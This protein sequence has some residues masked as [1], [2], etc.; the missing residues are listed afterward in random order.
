MESSGPSEIFVKIFQVPAP[1]TFRQIAE[2]SPA[3]WIHF[4]GIL[5][6]R[7]N[8]RVRQRAQ[9][10]VMGRLSTAVILLLAAPALLAQSVG[11]AIGGVITDQSGSA[12]V[13]VAVSIGDRISGRQHVVTTGSSGEYRV[14]ALPPS[15]YR[16]TVAVSGFSPVAENVTLNVNDDATLDLELA[17]A[18]VDAGV[19]STPGAIDLVHHEPSSIVTEEQIQSL[20]EIGRN[21]LQLAQLL[22]GSAPLNAS[23]NRFATTRFGGAADQ[24]SAVTTLIDGG[25]VDDAQ[26]G[27]PTINLSQDGVQEF[28]VY[29]NQFGAQYG[30]ALNA[31]VSVVTKSGGNRA[32]G[33]GFYFGRDAALNARNAFARETPPFDEQRLGATFGGPIA[34][35]RTHIFSAYEYDHVDTAR[36][37]AHPPTSRFAI[38]NGVFPAT[39]DD[40]MFSL[41]IDHQFSAG[42]TA[43][44]RYAHAN[45]NIV[46]LQQFPTS[47]SSQ[48][49]TFSRAHSV[50]AEHHAELSPRMFN[51]LRLHVFS[52]TSGGVPH[53]ADRVAAVARPSVNM[54]LVN[55]GE[56]LTFPRTEITVA[57]TIYTTRGRHD[58]SFGGEMGF[59]RNRLEGRFFED[60]LFRFQTDTQFDRDV[61]ATWP[62]SFVQQRP[63][64]DTYRTHPVA[65]FVQDH[66]RVADRLRVN[67][68]LR[69]DL[70]PTLRLN[71]V[72]AKALNDPALS[73][74]EAFVSR[75]RGTDSN[76]L[77]PR[78]GVTYDVTGSGTVVARGGFG[79]Y[80]ARN[81]PWFQVRAMNQLSGYAIRIEDPNQ[82]RLYPDVAAVVG[83]GGPRE[84]GTVIPDEFSQASAL[85]TTAGVGW[86]A[87]RDVSID[88]DY[89]HSYGARQYGTT[90]RNLPPTGT[91]GPTNPRP[92]PQF[93]QVAMLE[94]F[95]TSWHHALESQLRM[96]LGHR[97]RVQVSYTLSRTFLDG[98]DFFLTQRGTQ[99]TPQERGYS[100]SDQRHNLALAA[101]IAM[102]AGFD[103]SAILKLVSGSPLSVQAGSDLDG[104]R[105]PTGDRPPGLPITVGRADTARDLEI[106]NSF[107]ATLATPLEAVSP[108]LLRLEP[109]R[110]LDARLT[111]TWIVGGDR[112]IELLF[113]AFNLL[114]RVNFVVSAASRN[115]NS[116]QFLFRTS[117]RDARQVQWGARLRF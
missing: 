32:S 31:V 117:A 74:L 28:R 61:R 4:A 27:T 15:S 7:R 11:A 10:Q 97:G 29:R 69:Y 46:R 33:S 96:G 1:G 68:G 59:G 114:N 90:D 57:D 111:K 78:A 75:D 2:K 64:V 86:K 65:L 20:P 42:H 109:Y 107:R 95:T 54:G 18:G 81:R 103:V 36:L 24:R 115:I 16:V 87:G 104:D 99:R 70:D 44:V 84:I 45:Q 94:N 88:I 116:P 92:V 62:Q 73:G 71:D 37:I 19:V 22:P 49:D 35:N 6:R 63:S 3:T 112:R 13:G 56:W 79:V 50:V 77:Q 83:A 80:V 51:S 5:F 39:S 91:V 58:L 93:A 40:Q 34:R 52:H 38:E 26:W 47:D 82:L 14:I 9:G 21:F 101:S 53:H 105:S 106:I 85:N 102:P 60:G 55:G 100:P 25:D 48:V 67:L 110:T 113:E 41:R 23:V 12:L 17:I 43:T 66:W 98:V 76:N 89:V 30:N 108:E 8:L 72:Y